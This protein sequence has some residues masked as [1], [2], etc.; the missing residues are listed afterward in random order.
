MHANEGVQGSGL[1][2]FGMEPIS[3]PW[4][5]IFKLKSTAD[6]DPRGHYLHTPVMSVLRQGVSLSDKPLVWKE[7]IKLILVFD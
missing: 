6:H 2:W 5:C 3:G 1:D 4:E 7:T